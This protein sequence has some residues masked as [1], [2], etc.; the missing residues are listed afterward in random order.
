MSNRSQPVHPHGCGEHDCGLSIRCPQSGSSP[1]MWGTQIFPKCKRGVSRFIPTDVGNTDIKNH[2]STTNTVHPHGCGE[3]QI[4]ID[5]NLTNSGSSPRMWG[6]RYLLLVLLRLWR[7]IPT[8][9]GNTWYLKIKTLI[10]TVH[11][12][13]CGEHFIIISSI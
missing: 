12:H 10:I 11:P 2:Q 4:L 9:V 7:F 8:D 6:T 1:R 3:H 13:G 5:L